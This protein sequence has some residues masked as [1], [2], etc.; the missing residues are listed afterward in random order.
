MFFEK[1]KL[2]V[3]HLF[4]QSLLKIVILERRNA[5]GKT[6]FKPATSWNGSEEDKQRLQEQLELLGRD[7]SILV[8]DAMLPELNNEFA[9]VSC[10]RGKKPQRRANFSPHLTP[11]HS[12][13]L[14][15]PPSHPADVPHP[16]GLGVL[17]LPV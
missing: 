15:P 5:A 10:H 4:F 9:S 11:F 7:P 1:T 2:K 8:Q 6:F 13:S 17:R 14:S 12:L 3:R 16:M